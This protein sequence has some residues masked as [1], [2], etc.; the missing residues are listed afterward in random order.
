MDTN[1]KSNN[2]V[3]GILAYLGILVIIPL[4]TDSRN[5]PFV[6]FHVKQGLV[7]LICD[8]IVGLFWQTRVLG[9]VLVPLLQF[10]IF[11]LVVI[12][13][14]NVLNKQMKELPLIGQLAS[15]FKF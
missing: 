14:I 10:A 9:W 6:K 3:M 2:T 5:N 4:L 11:V 7:L 15:N 1:T 13:I 12:G 8:V